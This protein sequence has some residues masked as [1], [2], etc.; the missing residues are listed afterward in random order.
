[1]T[2]TT[3]YTAHG[4]KSMIAMSYPK[5]AQDV[6]PGA[7]ILCADGSIVMEVVSTNPKAGT[8]VARCKN[9][10]MLGWVAWLRLGLVWGSFC[11]GRVCECV[12]ACEAAAVRSPRTPGNPRPNKSSRPLSSLYPVSARTSTSPASL[13]TCPR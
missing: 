5:L 6:K 13:S 8:V 4:N 7:A 11:D 12:P 2:I 9:T 1:M 3:D 10:A